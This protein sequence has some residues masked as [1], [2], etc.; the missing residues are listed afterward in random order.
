M[1]RVIMNKIPTSKQLHALRSGVTIFAP[2]YLFALLK[3]IE[4]D[5]TEQ[6]KDFDEMINKLAG[7]PLVDWPK[8]AKEDYYKL[9]E[10]LLNLNQLKNT[11]AEIHYFLIYIITEHASKYIDN[12]GQKLVLSSL[13][14]LFND[15][16]LWGNE[17]P[18]ESALSK[19]RKSNNF[20]FEFSSQIGK[21][22][23]VDDS[24]LLAN[25]AVEVTSISKYFI[26]PALH[27][28]FV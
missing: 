1:I 10:T 18:E 3:I 9:L 26:Q 11:F 6:K 19:Y 28:I 4:A 12:E 14:D 24:L 22:A 25:F 7:L 17:H 5:Q 13:L 15:K 27:K 16:Q 8:D 2:L 23:G 21:T 20:L